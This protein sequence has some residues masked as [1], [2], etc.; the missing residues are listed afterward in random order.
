MPKK[1]W[2][3]N[4][5]L[6]IFSVFFCIFR[7]QPGVRDFCIFSDFS[8]FRDSAFLGSV[9]GPQDRN[10]SLDFS[11]FP[12]SSL[13]TSPKLL[14]LWLLRVIQRFPRSS[15]DCPRSFPDLP[16]VTRPLRKS[17]PL[18]AGSLTPSDYNSQRVPLT[19]QNSCSCRTDDVPGDSQG[20]P[21]K[22]SERLGVSPSTP[23]RILYPDYSS[24]RIH[25]ILPP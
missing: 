2:P 6:R 20:R 16:E 7:G 13:A 10:Q 12:R 14:S 4:D 8:Y 21:R 15:P 3:E 11:Q 5:N 18:S 22:Y 19:E 24:A 17:T 23:Q 9:A 1:K 25:I